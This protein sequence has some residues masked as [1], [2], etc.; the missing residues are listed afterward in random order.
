MNLGVWFWA[1][2]RFRPFKMKAKTDDEAATPKIFKRGAKA[3]G[4][5]MT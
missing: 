1:T 5:Q 4:W 3:I 2:P